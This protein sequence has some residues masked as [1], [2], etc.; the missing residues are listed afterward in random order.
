MDK[1]S[2]HNLGVILDYLRQ[3]NLTPMLMIA[4]DKVGQ[5]TI[6]ACGTVHPAL[7]NLLLAKVGEM[8][9]VGHINHMDEDG[10]PLRQPDVTR[11]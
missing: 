8:A 11:N 7:I 5:L 3:H 9:A 1:T 4:G 6:F 10:K 2:E